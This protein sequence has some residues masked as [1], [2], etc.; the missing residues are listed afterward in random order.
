LS[1]LKSH[2]AFFDIRYITSVT[3]NTDWTFCSA[4]MRKEVIMGVVS[5]PPAF[6]PHRHNTEAAAAA[7]AAAGAARQPC[8]AVWATRRNDSQISATCSVSW[9]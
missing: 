1:I 3:N 2:H 8:V 5:A 7:A 9:L 6:P 4:S